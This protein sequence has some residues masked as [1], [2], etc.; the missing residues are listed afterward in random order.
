MKA[1][2]LILLSLALVNC[3]NKKFTSDLVASNDDD[4]IVD[5]H[6][7]DTGDDVICPRYDLIIDSKGADNK[8]HNY[9]FTFNAEMTFKSTQGDIAISFKNNKYSSC[10]GN[11]TN[12]A[13]QSSLV[14]LQATEDLTGTVMIVHGQTC[15]TPGREINIKVVDAA[16]GDV[17]FNENQQRNMHGCEF[18]YTPNGQIL[19]QNL[20]SLADAVADAKGAAC[21]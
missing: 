14:P 8:R 12:N 6:D 5:D 17:L 4:V 16:T 11:Y 9:T 13:I 21:N 7:D 15:P 10:S 3:S 2:L 20:I 1:L 18:S 19:R